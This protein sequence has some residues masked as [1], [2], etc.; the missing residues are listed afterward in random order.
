M[1]YPPRR[2]RRRQRRG[3]TT[4]EVALTLGIF[5]TVT[6]GMFDLS[7]GV[8]RYHVISHAARQG[9]RRAIVHGD[10]AAA[11]GSW[12][13]ATVGPL[14]ASD[15][16]VHDIVDGDAGLSVPTSNDGISDLFVTCVKSETEILLQWPDGT[17]EF[18]DFVSVTVS[19]PY[20]PIMFFIFGADEITLTASSTMM[21]AH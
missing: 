8:F 16:G 19:T 18:E 4:L 7:I 1:T 10:R 5:L 9:A 21:I 11:L 2:S 3:A 13:P 12:G 14:Y 17:N 6:L 15:V 20:Q